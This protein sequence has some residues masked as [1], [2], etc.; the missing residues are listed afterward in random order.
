[1][2]D[3]EKLKEM[4]TKANINYDEDKNSYPNR[5]IIRIKSYST[6]IGKYKINAIFDFSIS[7]ELLLVG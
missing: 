4:L 6:T 3:L 1:M 5:I 7:G 2:N